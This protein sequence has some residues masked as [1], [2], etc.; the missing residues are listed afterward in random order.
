MPDSTDGIQAMRERMNRASR[1]PPPP[2]QPPKNA[3]KPVPETDAEAVPEKGVREDAATGS[4]RSRPSRVAATKP[5][6]GFTAMELPSDA[7]PVNLAIRVRRP[8]DDRLAEL[9]HLLRRRGV[10]TSKVELIEMLLWELPEPERAV[11]STLER[12]GVF[13]RHA[14]RAAGA[15]IPTG[16]SGR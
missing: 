9:I 11:E 10:R 14:A 1:K 16:R 8:L 12:L 3:P 13:R 6:A 5:K 7:P 15:E 4:I 2:R